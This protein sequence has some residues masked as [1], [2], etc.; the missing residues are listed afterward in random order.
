MK[1]MTLQ[2]VALHSSFAKRVMPG[3]PLFFSIHSTYY[4]SILFLHHCQKMSN[5]YKIKQVLKGSEMV[6]NKGI[7]LQNPDLL[8]FCSKFMQKQVTALFNN[9][10]AWHV[11][12]DCS[13]VSIPFFCKS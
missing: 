9:H 1:K 8:V 2:F 3:A 10:L 5:L 12:K 7:F 11:W 4:G 6:L 13:N